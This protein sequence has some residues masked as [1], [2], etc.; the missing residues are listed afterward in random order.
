MENEPTYICCN[1]GEPCTL[2]L[3]QRDFLEEDGYQDVYYL[4]ECCGDDY[5]E[6]EE[7]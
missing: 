6:L 3:I 2:R 4:S 7:D 1:C 5:Y